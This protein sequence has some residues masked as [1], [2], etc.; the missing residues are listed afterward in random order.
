MKP[1]EWQVILIP[2]VFL[3]PIKINLLE[4]RGKEKGKENKDVGKE[5]VRR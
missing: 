4:C 2:E 5:K 1:V 3:S